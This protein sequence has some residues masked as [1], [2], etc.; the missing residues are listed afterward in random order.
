MNVINF[1]FWETNKHTEGSGKEVLAQK[2]VATSLK[3]NGNF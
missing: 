2:H 1:V 3:S